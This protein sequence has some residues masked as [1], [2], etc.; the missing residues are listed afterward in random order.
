MSDPQIPVSGFYCVGGT[1]RPE[2]PSY[3]ERQADLELYERVQDGNACWVLTTRQT[4][5]SS[6]MVRTADRLR[7]DGVVAVIIDLTSIGTQ[8]ITAAE[9][10]FGV[11]E[12]ILDELNL[13]EDVEAWWYR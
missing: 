13:D 10:Y 2:A 8:E 9:W 1:M 4:G 6:L 12:S 3:L 5:K 11:A 7:K